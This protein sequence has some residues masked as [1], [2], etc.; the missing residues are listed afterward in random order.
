MAGAT[1]KYKISSLHFVLAQLGRH[2][3]HETQN[4][5]Q[6]VQR[7]RPVHIVAP[8]VGSDVVLLSRGGCIRHHKRRRVSRTGQQFLRS[9][10]TSFSSGFP[11]CSL[12][13]SKT[14]CHGRSCDHL[15]PSYRSQAGATSTPSPMRLS[16]GADETVTTTSVQEDDLKCLH[17]PLE[18][19]WRDSA[20]LEKQVNVCSCVEP[21][22]G[23]LWSQDGLLVA[24]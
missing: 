24:S 23:G 11:T 17:K 10:L 8:F 6:H 14:D 20:D 15:H 19:W 7:Q 9:F 3:N 2:K 18:V 21:Q 22:L 4:L 12:K 13:T 5:V 16:N 1:D